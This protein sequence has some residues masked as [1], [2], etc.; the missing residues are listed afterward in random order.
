MNSFE[1]NYLLQ[2]NK[3]FDKLYNDSRRPANFSLKMP[4]VPGYQIKFNQSMKTISDTLL[5]VCTVSRGLCVDL[6][7]V[8]WTGAWQGSGPAPWTPST[9]YTVKL[10]SHAAPH[11]TDSVSTVLNMRG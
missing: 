7:L 2:L 8:T 4:F 9:L 5:Q 11:R 1:E 10:T 3:Q 6:G